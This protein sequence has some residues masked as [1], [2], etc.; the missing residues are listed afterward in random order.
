M[1]TIVKHYNEMEAY[2]IKIS[3]NLS[4]MM[5]FEQKHITLKRI[6]LSQSS[7]ILGNQSK[8]TS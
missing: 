7:G 8:F 1:K 6:T 2:D 3:G 4:E 5:G